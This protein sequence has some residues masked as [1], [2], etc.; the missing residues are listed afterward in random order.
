M[1][2]KKPISYEAARNKAENYCIKVERCRQE[3]RK[4]LSQ[5]GT[6]P[7][8][9]EKILDKLID[10]RFI[11]ETRYARAFVRDK[12]RF[13]GWGRKK[14]EMSLKMKAVDS[15]DINEGLE[16]IDEQEYI[17]ILERLLKNKKKSTKAESD[18]ELNAKLMRFAAGRGFEPSIISKIL[19]FDY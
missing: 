5:W 10:D 14:I 13:N 9:I 15:R 1:I 11:D 4:K 12:Y 16:E 2:N 3:V 17:D 19:H 8:D 6:A 7:E 18:Y